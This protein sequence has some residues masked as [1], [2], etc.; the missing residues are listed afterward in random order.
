MRVFSPKRAKGQASPIQPV[1]PLTTCHGLA[2][3]HPQ[4]GKPAQDASA[5]NDGQEP[6]EPPDSEVCELKSVTA[7]RVITAR[8]P[9][10]RTLATGPT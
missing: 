7:S 4:S 8:V 6:A 9:A 5:T 3:K 10:E 2:G 1:P